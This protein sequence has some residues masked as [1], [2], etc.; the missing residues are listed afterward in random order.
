MRSALHALKRPPTPGVLK[1]ILGALGLGGSALMLTE[2]LLIK[3]HSQPLQLIAPIAAATGLSVS[4]MPAITQNR[5]ARVL[6]LVIAL[7]LMLAGGIGAVVHLWRNAEVTNSRAALEVLS[8]PFP[9]LAPLAL[10]N[11]GALT[12][13]VTTRQENP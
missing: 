12:I 7:G 3:H 1:W 8:G 10:A 5:A 6:S 4:L 9:A 11:I 13:W 2:L